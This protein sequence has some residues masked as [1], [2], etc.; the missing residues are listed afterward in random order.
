MVLSIVFHLLDLFSLNKHPVVGSFK[1]SKERIAPKGH[2]LRGG[3]YTTFPTGL[4]ASW[5]S[6]K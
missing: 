5:R 6:E 2:V 4:A 1:P 3:Y